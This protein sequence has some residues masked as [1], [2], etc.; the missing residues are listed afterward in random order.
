MRGARNT[1]ENFRRLLAE[2]LT[3]PDVL[4][5]LAA[6]LFALA[7]GT[8]A[9]ILVW[10]AQSAHGPPDNASGAFALATLLVVLAA[11][12]GLADLGAT[13]NPTSLRPIRPAGWT[14]GRKS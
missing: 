1:P 9:A 10:R 3:T 5:V 2:A 4:I 7:V 14:F 11:C 12:P 8:V 6:A 13:C